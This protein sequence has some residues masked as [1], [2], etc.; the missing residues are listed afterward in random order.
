MRLEDLDKVAVLA[1]VA[2]RRGRDAERLA[3][4]QRLDEAAVAAGEAADAAGDA[5]L[6]LEALGAKIPVSVPFSPIPFHLLATPEV[7]SLL[8]ALEALQ[9]LADS[10]DK[11]R[12]RV[13][14]TRQG[15]MG[16]DVAEALRQLV[17]RLSLEV[18]GPSAAVTGGRE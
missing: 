10:V 4:C 3:L 7:Q 17:A 13:V 11:N 1:Q 2:E 12:N 8:R 14:E 5:R 15:P 9:P 6:A 18:H 16:I